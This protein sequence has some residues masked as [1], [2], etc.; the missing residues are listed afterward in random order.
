MVSA[1]NDKTLRLWNISSQETV[2]RFGGRRG[3][4]HGVRG[5]R[6]MKDDRTIVSASRDHTLKL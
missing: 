5:C 2:R 6:V 3:H 1:S 4:R